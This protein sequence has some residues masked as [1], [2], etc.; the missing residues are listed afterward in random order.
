M[1]RL[2]VVGLMVLSLAGCKRQAETT[3]SASAPAPK[4]APLV[5]KPSFSVNDEHASAYMLH[6]F[7]GLEDNQW[8][9]AEKKFGVTLGEPMDAA[10]NGA[11]LELKFAYLE[12]ALKKAGP[13]TVSATVNGQ[14]LLPETYKTAGRHTYARDLGGSTFHGGPVTVEFTTDKALPPNPPDIRELSIIVT[15]VGLSPR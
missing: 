7:S 4:D 14:P 3:E 11:R 10:K 5:L 2:I 8:R 12:Q 6:G 13:V 9:W 15:D 1:R